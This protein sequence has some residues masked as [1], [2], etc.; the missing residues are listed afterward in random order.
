MH[1]HLIFSSIWFLERNIFKEYFTKHMIF[2]TFQIKISSAVTIFEEFLVYMNQGISTGLPLFLEKINSEK[3]Q[4]FLLISKERFDLFAVLAESVCQSFPNFQELV[5]IARIGGSFLPIHGFFKFAKD[6]SVFKM[7]SALI[8][9]R[10]Q[11]S[12]CW[13]TP[14]VILN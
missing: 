1:L 3:S 5:K 11:T 7:G 6:F 14:A 9:T 4:R 10:L 13:A 12:G 8:R 2:N